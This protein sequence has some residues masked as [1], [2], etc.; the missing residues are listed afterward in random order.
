[1]KFVLLI[2]VSFG[3]SFPPSFNLDRQTEI[4]N[5]VLPS[6]VIIDIEA[7]SATQIY[8]GTSLGLGRVDID[9][10]S[11]QNTK[12]MNLS[13]T[14]I[15][16][17]INADGMYNDKYPNDENICER[18]WNLT[19]YGFLYY[20]NIINYSQSGNSNNFIYSTKIPFR[21]LDECGGTGE[22]LFKFNV[23]DMDFSNCLSTETNACLVNLTSTI[24]RSLIIT[25]CGDDYCTSIYESSA[26]CPEDCE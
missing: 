14:Y 19:D 15:E 16:I 23:H 25:G 7:I 26:S 17:Q 12:Y 22:A 4:V 2:I 13:N 3:F 8:F 9:G 1:M 6:N 11:A 18:E 5:D 24:E 20:F 10:V 21:P